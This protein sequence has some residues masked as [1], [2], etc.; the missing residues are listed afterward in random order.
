[1]LNRA[2][3]SAVARKQALEMWR[4]GP[5]ISIV[6]LGMAVWFEWTVL[7]RLLPVLRNAAG[8][9][10]SPLG[11]QLLSAAPT[12]SMAYLPLIIIPIFG[13]AMLTRS[14]TGDL[15]SGSLTLTMSTGLN[16]GLLW[17]TQVI[18]VF[19][20]GYLLTIVAWVVAVTMIITHLRVGLALTAPYLIAILV[21][22]PLCALCILSLL[23]F[24]LWTIRFA[25]VLVAML[26][27][28]LAFVI[29][30]LAA[31][32]PA[33]RFLA[34]LSVFALTGSL[35]VTGLC[36]LSISRLRRGFIVGL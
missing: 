20:G 31:T 5:L 30:V 14:H 15:L 33:T 22:S 16:P 3:L 28:T 19:L 32:H 7:N 29:L 9:L 12:L 24:C 18:T 27:M 36:G 6:A 23:A 17:G 11:T 13:Q 25:R 21:L 8:G 26:P 1:M 4:S 35:V 2:T 10:D 34:G